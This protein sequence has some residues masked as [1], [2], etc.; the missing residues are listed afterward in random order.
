MRICFV[1]NECSF[2]YSHR[3]E[4][5]KQLNSLGEVCLIADLKNTNSEI[6]KKI[7]NANI[8]LQHIEKRSSVKG[9]PG[10]FLYY[11]RLL[12]AIKNIKPKVLFFVTLEISIIGIMISWIFSRIHSFY[13]ITGFGKYFFG[14]RLKDRLFYYAY[15]GIFFSARL[16][17]NTKFIFQN[18]ED[19]EYFINKG[20]SNNKSCIL[21]HGSG[22]EK[23]KA[24]KFNTNKGSMIS[25][26]FS[27]R[28]VIA[29]GLGEFVKAAEKIKKKH[30]KVTIN[31]LGKYDCNDP[32]KIS[33]EL[34]KKIHNS[35]DINYFGEVS[36]DKVLEHY[37][38]SDIFVLPSHGE[39]LPKAALEAAA[40]GMPLIL[41][42]V[43]G[44]KECLVEKENGIFVETQN[45]QN[46][47]DAMEYFIKHPSEIIRMGTNSQNLIEKKF[48]IN[49]I[50]RS[51]KNLLSNIE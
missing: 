47:V 41:S 10:M 42:E 33:E 51:Y 27:S 7:Q 2:F 50:S 24:R 20:L 31:I 40:S 6:I 21:I 46:I 11:C 37:Q 32:D 25:F 17:R 45:I 38:N 14:K 43:S 34:F 48:S 8:K 29:K 19:K 26:L 5:A 35:N 49:I 9:L 30:P 15:K 13:L 22:V 1:V 3:F 4:L 18:H 12:I 44:C 36:Y 39:G 16:N 28:L 23:Y